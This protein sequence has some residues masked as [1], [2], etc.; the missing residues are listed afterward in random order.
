MGHLASDTALPPRCRP[1]LLPLQGLTAPG[2]ACLVGK[3]PLWGLC[4]QNNSVSLAQIGGGL[5][6]CGAV[7]SD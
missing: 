1:V 3:D 6:L 2:G 4:G 7:A 5:S